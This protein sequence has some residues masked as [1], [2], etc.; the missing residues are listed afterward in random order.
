MLVDLRELQSSGASR[1]YQKNCGQRLMRMQRI[2][3]LADLRELQSS[4]ASRMYQ[5]M[6]ISIF[7]ARREW[8]ENR[9]ICT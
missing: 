1:M 6:R 4:G 9:S 3:M 2:R 8:H 7:E 5:K